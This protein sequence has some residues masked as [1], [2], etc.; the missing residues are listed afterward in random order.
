MTLLELERQ[1]AAFVEEDPGNRIE[2]SYALRP[3]YVGT[4]IYEAPLIGCAAAKDPLFEYMKQR[5]DIYGPTLRLPEEWLPGAASVVSFFLP[6]SKAVRDSNRGDL[7]R[8]SDLWLHGRVEGQTFLNRAATYLA[9]LLREAGG[10]VTV[11]SL[12]S[13]FYVIRDP[14]RVERGEPPYV[15][16]W[17]ERHVAFTAGLG[18]FSLSKHLITEKG[19]CGRFG[20][21][22]T[23]LPLP[24]TPRPYT[25]PY[26]YCTFCGACR[27]RCIVD[28]IGPQEKDNRICSD[29]QHQTLAR[30][31]PRHGCGKCQLSVPCES[32]RPKRHL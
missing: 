24:V 20:S 22:I 4:Q 1:L 5:A 27:K 15:S 12:D 31:S 28:A 17:S 2:E 18:T 32:R 3:E 29:Y 14:S 23:N 8:P 26:E 19:V 6:F 11:P 10:K 21:V 16:N 30:F 7:S 9:E 25:D 13:E